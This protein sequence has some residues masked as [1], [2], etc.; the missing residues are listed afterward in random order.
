MLFKPQETMIFSIFHI[1]Y[2]AICIYMCVC[3]CVSNIPTKLKSPLFPIRN[4]SFPNY[5]R[6]ETICITNLDPIHFYVIFYST[7]L[8]IL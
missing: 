7:D 8:C 1:S 2:K 5:H 3:V 4:M 6:L